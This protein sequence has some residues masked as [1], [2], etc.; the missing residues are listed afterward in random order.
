MN[1][2]KI[3][4]ALTAGLINRNTNGNALLS[5]KELMNQFGDDV[6]TFL[7]LTPQS[8]ATLDSQTIRETYALQYE[9]CTLNVNLVSHPAANR[10]TIQGF[11]IS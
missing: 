6:G 4:L 2:R 9:R 8:R 7:G 10:Q 5:V 3:K 1:T 11:Y